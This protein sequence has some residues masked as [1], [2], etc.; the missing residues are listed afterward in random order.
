MTARY[1]LTPQAK[2]DLALIAEYITESS[3]LA[4]AETV[5]RELQRNF[6]LLAEHPDIGHCREDITDDPVVRFWSVYSYLVVFAP[7]A[8]KLTVLSILH[9]ARDSRVIASRIRSAQLGSD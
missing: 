1:V 9:G 7:E 2:E 3:G 6:Q 4:T 5:V 8:S